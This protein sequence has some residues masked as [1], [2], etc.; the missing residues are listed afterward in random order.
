MAREL[1]MLKSTKSHH[2]YTTHVNTKMEGGLDNSGKL[3]L[4]KYDPVL[5]EHVL[6]KQKKIKK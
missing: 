1:V 3:G 6:Y 5:R 2:F 4:M